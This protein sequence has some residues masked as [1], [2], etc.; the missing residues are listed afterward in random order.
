MTN[1]E[2]IKT[3]EIAIAEVEWEYPMKYAVAFEKAI[4]AL[5]KQ[6]P[7]K[8][9]PCTNQ[10]SNLYICPSCNRFIAK[11]EQSHGNIDI[12]YCKWCGQK[13]DWGDES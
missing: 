8:P 4:E 10:K 9:S 12:P 5:K 1:E 11:N 3:I 13:L 2:A 6:V 7:Q